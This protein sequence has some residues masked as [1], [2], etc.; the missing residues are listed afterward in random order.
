MSI[1]MDISNNS[2]ANESGAAAKPPAEM[3]V[4]TAATAE[5]I[6]DFSEDDEDDNNDD[7]DDEINS[8]SSLFSILT[9]HVNDNTNDGSVSDNR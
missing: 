3:D 1:V 2:D 6:T 5:S 7:D 9:M 4:T 8:I